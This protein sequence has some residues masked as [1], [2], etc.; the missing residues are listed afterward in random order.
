MCVRLLVGPVVV[1]ANSFA[2]TVTIGC[3]TA[4]DA[5]GGGRLYCSVFHIGRRGRHGDDVEEGI[6]ERRAMSLVIRY[7]LI[8]P[9]CTYANLWY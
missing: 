6:G 2:S 7:L 1:L 9:S 5:A 4:I 8:P 3:V